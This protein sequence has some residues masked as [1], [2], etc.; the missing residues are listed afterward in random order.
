MM[1]LASEQSKNLM[2]YGVLDRNDFGLVY[3]GATW[4]LT[5]SSNGK[6]ILDIKMK[7][8]VLYVNTWLNHA[9]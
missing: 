4:A 9:T 6:V 5:K 2:S 8:N 3:N 1:F 7:N